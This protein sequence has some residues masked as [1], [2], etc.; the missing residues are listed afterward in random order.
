MMIVALIVAYDR[1]R[2]IGKNNKLPWHLPA[3]L[4]HFKRTTMGKP[5]VMGRRT[6]DS[7][8]RPLPGRRNVV[9][10]RAPLGI[11]GVESFRSLDEALQACAKEPEVMVIGGAQLFAWAMPLAERIWATEIDADYDVDTWFPRLDETAWRE[12]S[13]EHRAADAR[14]PHAMDFVVYERRLQPSHRS[15]D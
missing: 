7:I 11:P 8:G 6:F 12:V 14:T 1:N 10:S 13:R 5:I 9:I 4:A 3:E 15:R 2:G